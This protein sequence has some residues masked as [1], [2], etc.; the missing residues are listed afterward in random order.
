MKKTL[1]CHQVDVGL[2][3]SQLA[4]FSSASSVDA[5]KKMR[6]V[7]LLVK[8]GAN[9]S[10]FFIKIECLCFDEILIKILLFDEIK[11]NALTENRKSLSKYTGTDIFLNYIPLTRLYILQDSN[12]TLSICTDFN[13]F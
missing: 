8:A 9:T 7:S 1:P 10:N 2:N 12:R 11:F 6:R 4:F 5:D 3:A 13:H